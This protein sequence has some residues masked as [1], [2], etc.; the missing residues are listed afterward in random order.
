MDE[1]DM[2]RTCNGSL[3]VQNLDIST[4]IE[5]HENRVTEHVLVTGGV[6]GVQ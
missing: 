4:M 3:P 2:S 1:P 6:Q 5:K